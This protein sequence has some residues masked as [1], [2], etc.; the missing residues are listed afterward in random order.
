MP[1][2]IFYRL[3]W[4]LIGLFVDIW[5]LVRLF[6]G[7]EE[8]SRFKERAGVASVK[9]P[10]GKLV[11]FHCASVGECLS[12]LPLINNLLNDDD[13]LNILVTSGTVTS[14]KLMAK[15][16]PARAIHQYVPV[17][18]YIPV[19]NFMWF[20]KPDVS[21]FVESEFWPELLYQAPNP[22]LLNARISKRS[23]VRYK[24]HSWLTRPLIKRFKACLCQEQADAD[25]LTELGAP[26]AFKAGNLKFDALP[27]DADPHKVKEFKTAINKRPVVVCA[28]THNPEE[29]WHG[30][31]HQKIT[32]EIPNVLTI[33]APRHPERGNAIAKELKAMGMSIKQRS[34]DEMPQED[35]A[36]FVADSLGE[37]GLWYTLADAAVMGGSF[38]PHGGQNPLEPLKLNTATFAGPHMFNFTEMMQKL[39]EAE[40]IEQTESLEELGRTLVNHLKKGKDTS[41][42][43]RINTTMAELSGSTKTAKD[44]ILN[45]L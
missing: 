17:D 43:R 30:L 16:L 26:N 44:E 34:K 11:W 38:V 21:V 13:S 40:A 22:I 9:R 32:A 15:K 12:I 27:L 33:I 5:L 29:G 35:T 28:S 18:F 45:R 42:E 8:W 1:N 2:I 7:K 6:K 10:E 20:W 39:N 31:V 14:A 4:V 36:I 24:K 25:R 41:L 23:F 3:L 19:K 37:M